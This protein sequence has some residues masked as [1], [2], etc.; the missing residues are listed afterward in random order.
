MADATLTI[1]VSTLAGLRSAIDATLALCP[2][3]VLDAMDHDGLTVTLPDFAGVTEVEPPPDAE[4]RPQ[5]PRA[6]NAAAD[7]AGS[8]AKRPAKAKPPAKRGGATTKGETT[9]GSVTSRVLD[10]LADGPID[11]PGGR[12]A[13]R[14]AARLDVNTS[15]VAQALLELERNGRIVR[16]RPS[17]RRTTRIDLA[18][19]AAS[20]PA[21]FR[22]T[23]TP[24]PDAP[25]VDA[26]GR[27]IVDQ[28]RT[29]GLRD[30]LVARAQA[31]VE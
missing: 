30:K 19:R 21:P 27:G 4:E 28:V 13:A 15:H 8:K 14:I 31:A 7:G 25:K 29:D 5:R 12:V 17:P 11:D 2:G 9:P 6:V 26:P 1:P 22:P 18:D 10:L 23:L 20:T 24:A 16:V 3:A